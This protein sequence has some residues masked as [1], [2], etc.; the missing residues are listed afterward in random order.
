MLATTPSGADDP[1][2]PPAPETAEPEL[3]DQPPGGED[4]DEMEDTGDGDSS[5]GG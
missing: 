4:I 2:R 5:D 1:G 3:R